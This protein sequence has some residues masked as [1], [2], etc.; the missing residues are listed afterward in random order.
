VRWGN[1]DVAVGLQMARECAHPDA[2]WLAA[3]FPAGVAVTTEDMAKVLGEHGGDPRAMLISWIV[4]PEV[5]D[6]LLERAAEGDYAPAL[7]MMSSCAST[8]DDDGAS[9]R[10]AERAVALGDRFGFVRLGTCV[11]RGEGCEKNRAKGIEV[12]RKAA[13]LGHR[14]AQFTYGR[15]AFG[16]HDW[17]RYVWFGRAASKGF[18]QEFSNAVVKLVPLFERGELSRVLHT[19]A[20]LASAHLDRSERKVFGFRPFRRTDWKQLLRIVEL[21]EAM[22]G[23]A[24]AA[25]ACWSMAGLRC[26]VVKDMRVMIAK[27]AWEEVW[28]WG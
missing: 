8:A 21:H 6:S 17:E 13:E 26:G 18:G 3:L 19:V 7:G 15:M 9:F 12:F 23:R 14:G 4:H 25:L 16:K 10:F 28:R 20:S 11:I 5:A 24:R 27:I 2:R 22:R 1:G